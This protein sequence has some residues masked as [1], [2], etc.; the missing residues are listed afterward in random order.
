MS[1]AEA[2]TSRQAS[3]AGEARS[4]EPGLLQV[5]GLRLAFGGLQALD[6]VTF[7]VPAG[8]LSSLIG[9]NGAGKT[10]LFNAV[11][12]LLRPDS[13]RVRFA[14][15]AIQGLAPERITARGLV[16]TFQI[17][18]GF[19]ML[20]VFEHLMLYGQAQPGERFWR[21]LFGGGT[22]RRHEAGLAE[23][24]WT[25]ARQLRLD[26]VIDNRVTA[27]SG[28]QKKLLEIGR[29]LMA[30]PRMVLFDEPAAGVNPTLAEMIGDHLQQIARSGVTVLIIEHDMAL[31]GR[32]SEHVIVMAQG[33][34]LAQGSFDAIRNNLA[35]Q[36]AYFGVRR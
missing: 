10:T 29:A 36:D 4:P 20:T 9:P 16:R 22:A 26:P 17:A 31:I 19:P 23:Q 13:G 15:Q 25:I 28:G 21:A 8:R 11:S 3:G 12:G 34:T 35:V 1:F 32:I 27:L 2:S 14:G 24:A 18:R 7:S 33:R 30:R 6:G 5:D